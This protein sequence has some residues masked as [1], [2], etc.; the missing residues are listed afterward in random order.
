MSEIYRYDAVISYNHNP[1]DVRVARMLQQRL[2]HF[3][4]PRG[5]KEANG[6]DRIG[7]IFLDKGELEVTADLDQDIRNALEHTEYLIVICSPKAKGSRWI[8]REIE[9]FLQFH[10]KERILTVVTEGEPADVLP[11]NLLFREVALED[12]SVIREPAEPLSCDYRGPIRQANRTE[13]PR[14]AAALLGCKY[15]DLVQRQKHYRRKRMVLTLAAAA[16]AVALA[17]TYL[18]WSNHQI[19]NNYETALIE[20]SRTLAM[21][22]ENALSAGDRIGAAEYALQAL[23]GEDGDRPVV[24]EAVLALSRVTRIYRTPSMEETI[25]VR[26]YTGSTEQAF[27]VGGQLRKIQTGDFGDDSFLMAIYTDGSAWIWD[28]VTGKQLMGKRTEGL[29]EKKGT[30]YDGIF[31]GEGKALLICED[32]LTC[33]DLIRKEILWEKD[34]DW[35]WGQIE[36]RRGPLAAGG[37][38]WIPVSKAGREKDFICCIDPEDGRQ[39]RLIPTEGKA[40]GLCAPE[41]GRELAF[42]C[43]DPE[44]EESD[45]IYTLDADGKKAEEIGR[46]TTVTG[47]M[48]MDG[49]T[50]LVT[51][52]DQKIDEN[53]VTKYDFV[54][55]REEKGRSVYSLASEKGVH[56]L[57]MDTETGQLLWE[58]ECDE[59][60]SGYPSLQWRNNQK[61]FRGRIALT[62]GNILQF[63]DRAGNKKERFIFGSAVKQYYLFAEEEDEDCFGAV[64]QSGNRA[65]CDIR[66]KRLREDYGIFQSYISEAKVVNGSIVACSNDQNK[67]TSHDRLIQYRYAGS[68]QRWQD[69]EPAKAEVMQKTEAL[70]G[71]QVIPYKD[72]F[73]EVR[74]RFYP[75]KELGKSYAGIHV[76]RRDSSDGKILWEKHF[77][78]DMK[79]S[80]GTVGHQMECVGIDETSGSLCFASVEMREVRLGLIDLET[81]KV[82]T[83]SIPLTDRPESTYRAIEGA[84]AVSGGRICLGVKRE[85]LNGDSFIKQL[86]ILTVGLGEKDG[87]TAFP[88]QELTEKETADIDLSGPVTVDPEGSRIAL[89]MDG[90]ICLYSFDGSTRVKSD[91]VGYTIR[92]MT[93]VEDMLY[94]IENR[95]ER[96]VIHRYDAET[97]KEG[98]E[99][100]IDDMG[101]IYSNVLQIEPITEDEILVSADSRA[102]ILDARTWEMR[103]S[104][105]GFVSYN[106]Q[107][108]QFCLSGEEGEFGHIPYCGLDELIRIGKSITN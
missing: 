9:Y 19:R 88:L 80:D 65:T 34:Y 73:I 10:S 85:E 72:S 54:D 58:T 26:E 36:N 49:S 56:L 4:L 86:E 78:D 51:G 57:C 99:V 98:D 53:D 87:L 76:L 61:L 69:Y 70:T 105:D 100:I 22:S 96:T 15:D 24:S 41:D 60:F 32:S 82:R 45:R 62:M 101:S 94:T 106:P 55:I 93:F 104:M 89:A 40:M 38:I 17:L 79:N 43:R 42:S 83:R 1:V 6:K 23:P 16:F 13:L 29:R 75:D 90:R 95:Q 46:L 50:L 39:I 77:T 103:A 33:L 92:G 102:Y 47:L 48:Y 31:F 67:A 84:R 12:G 66:T 52:I 107:T 7:R 59:S 35:S 8:I 18:I 37:A 81:G 27:A 11:E 63:I 28:A 44:D 71:E 14:L 68:D 64:L 20:Q 2:E 21:Q 25:P 108:K 5:V 91:P 3:R 74:P 97:G 30:I